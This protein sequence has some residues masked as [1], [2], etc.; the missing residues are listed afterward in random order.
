MKAM[1]LAAG[2]GTRLRPY[3]RHTPKPLFTINGRPLLDIIVER[4]QQAGCKGAII[5]T[6]YHHKQIESYVAQR[7]YAFPVITRHEPEILGT[8]G[9]IRNMADFWDDAPMLVINADIVCDIDLAAVYAYHQDHASPVTMVMHDRKKFNSVSVDENDWVVG[10][11]HG[12]PDGS[13]GRQMAFTGIHVLDRRVLDFV[14]ASGPAH[15]IDAYQRMLDA[16]EQIQAYVSRDHYWQDI[17]TPQSYRKTVY[18]HMAPLAFEAAYGARPQGPIDCHRLQGDGS[19][20][21]WYR[22]ETESGQLIMADHG[23]REGLQ[24]Q[25]VDAYVDIGK[26]LWSNSAAVPHIWAYDRLAGLVFIEDLGDRNLQQVVAQQ[27]YSQR[28]VQ[29]KSV[30]DRWVALTML[31]HRGFDPHWTYQTDRYDRQVILENECRYFIEAFLRDFLGWDITFDEMALEFE[32][33]AHEAMKAGPIGLMHRDLQSRNIMIKDDIYFID[34]QGARLGPLQYDLASLLI[35]PYVG[36]PHSLQEELLD[37][38]ATELE[39][40]YDIDADIFSR[41]Y[42]YCAITRNLQMLGAFSHL[43]LVKGKSEFE[44]YL[45]GAIQILERRLTSNQSLTI[46]LPKLTEA[47]QR[48]AKQISGD[49][50]IW[51]SE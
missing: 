25:E 49:M 23:I 20:R 11:K 4:L 17:G 40:R 10:F 36:L 1:I 13:V 16:G 51:Q 47:T 33:L 15:I 21:R 43:S 41:G 27:S 9:G 50:G 18:D 35:D 29:Y 24:R 28:Q 32:A 8:G 37:Y 6:H 14:P 22:L 12:D 38:C 42:P 46:P 19:D 30:I 48:A 39:R 3:S 2:L 26:H 31:G 5:N 34:F 7:A 44:A 45:P